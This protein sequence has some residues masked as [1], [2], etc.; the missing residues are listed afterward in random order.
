MKRMIT[1]PIAIL[2]WHVPHARCAASR[3]SRPQPDIS[4]DRQDVVFSDL[5][6]L[7]VDAEVARPDL[8]MHESTIQPVFSPMANRSPFLQSLWQLRRVRRP[9]QGAN[10]PAL[11]TIRDDH[12]TGWSPTQRVLFASDANGLS[13]PNRAVQRAGPGGQA[14]QIACTRGAGV[15]SRAGDMI[16]TCADGTWYR[17]GYAVVQ[18]DVWICSADGPT[19]AS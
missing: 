11:P 10:R 4:A 14:R 12:P 19:I 18:R 13:K 16:A 8:T 6:D 7:G 2:C 1:L 3:S 15:F 17:K 9:V 5:G